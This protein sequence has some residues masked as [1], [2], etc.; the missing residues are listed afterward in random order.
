MLQEQIQKSLLEVY[1]DQRLKLEVWVFQPSAKQK[2]RKVGGQPYIMQD[3][4]L[5]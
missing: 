5:M 3:Q 4:H 2:D 1:S